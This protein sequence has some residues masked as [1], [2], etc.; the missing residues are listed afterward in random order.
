MKHTLNK[1][2]TLS[3]IVIATLMVASMQ[4]AAFA[5]GNGVTPLGL[6]I[7]GK[8]DEVV[9]GLQNDIQ[10][11]ITEKQLMMAETAEER[12]SIIEEKKVV[13]TEAIELANTER[14]DAI[15]AFEASEKTEEDKEAFVA[16][17]KSLATDISEAAKSMGGL[18]E[19]LGSLG[20]DLA[21]KLKANAQ[22]LS[23]QI[24]GAESEIGATGTAIAEDMIERD[25]PIPDNIPNIPDEIP[26]TDLP[27]QVPD[28]GPPTDLPEETPGE[29]PP[30]DLPDNVPEVPPTELPPEVPEI[31][32]VPIA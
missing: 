15:A 29:I 13:L 19:L 11:F 26:P 28:E 25:L 16:E 2:L 24:E 10:N 32:P 5:V 7:A 27:D 22:A 17:M 9:S 30:T 18:G 23:E 6:E 31:P 1:K 14:Q 3:A 4:M 20:Q 8:T 12:L 21:E